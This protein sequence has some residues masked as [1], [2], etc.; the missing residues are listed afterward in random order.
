MKRI[1]K[2]LGIIAIV[3]VIAVGFAGCPDD[4]DKTITLN[5][6]MLDDAIADAEYAKTGIAVATDGSEVFPDNKWVTQEEMTALD[7]VISSA[8]SV[9]ANATAQAQIDEAITMLTTAVIA[10]NNAKKDGLKITK[11]DLTQLIENAKELMETAVISTIDGE[12]IEAGE[13]WVTQDEMDALEEAL[14][15]AEVVEDEGIKEAYQA[16]KEAMENFETAKKSVFTVTFD[17][18]DGSTENE[19]QTVNEGGKATAPTEPT[20]DSHNFVYW[21]N[22]AN[23]IEWSFDTIITGNITLKAKW[24]IRTYTVT[25][26]ADNGT[27]ETTQTINHGGK[28]AKPIPDPVKGEFDF[29][30]WFNTANNTE[31]NFDLDTVNVDITLKAKWKMANSILLSENQWENVDIVSND[32]NW[33][34]FTATA[35]T[36]FIHIDDTGLY[37]AFVQLYDS[38]GNEVNDWNEKYLH[39]AI[40]S[41]KLYISNTTIIDQIYYIR[42]QTNSP[43]EN[44]EL[45]TI[46]FNDSL[47]PPDGIL[48]TENAWSM[49]TLSGQW[50]SFTATAETQFIHFDSN[51][52]TLTQIFVMVYDSAGNSVGEFNE[53]QLRFYNNGLYISRTVTVDQIYFIWVRSSGYNYKIG[54]NKSFIPPTEDFIILKEN[55]WTNSYFVLEINNAS[56]W[57][58]FTAT[59]ET[60]FIHFN[61]GEMTQAY[62]SLY[63]SNGT[64]VGGINLLGPGGYYTSRMTMIGE[65]YHIRV[66]PNGIGTY[67]IGFN[68][69][70]T[71]PQ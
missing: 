34:S 50:F 27:T 55:Y 61:R 71:A 66:L 70:S 45:L 1:A 47:M 22:I 33:F 31:W 65:I 51:D 10:F 63:D 25:F 15:E 36:Q 17:F 11:A 39:S 9:K 44:G 38:A 26:N 49:N 29:I 67:Q 8:K 40:G 32:V 30:H 35:E 4:D 23:N 58:S 68:T 69:S 62:V 28:A 7:S 60:Q 13:I 57:F 56:Q 41:T 18:D 43:S 14:E 46:A 6:E 37:L 12:N 19:T 54:F 52:E 2:I 48:L 64:M 5:Y 16:L 21:Y 59:A 53:T 20:K 24:E 3:A 42:V